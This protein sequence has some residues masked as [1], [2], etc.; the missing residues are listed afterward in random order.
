[1]KFIFFIYLVKIIFNSFNLSYGDTPITTDSGSNIVTT[2][3]I[4]DETRLSCMAHR[5]NTVLETAW[6]E[7]KKTHKDSEIFC[8]CVKDWRKF[9][10]QTSGIQDELPKSIECNSGTRLWRS[11]F[12]VHDSL[13]ASF[14]ALTQILTARNKQH[15]LHVL[16]GNLLTTSA[17]DRQILITST[18]SISSSSPPQKK[19]KNDPFADIRQQVPANP[20]L[21]CR[22]KQ[23][24]NR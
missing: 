10:N 3:K 22:Q 14:T 11:Y 20:S 5:C 16:A 9:I 18:D 2:F 13:N 1:M 17:D 7:T 19:P 12:K 8:S 4:T 23:H 6:D 21:S 15:R 24:L